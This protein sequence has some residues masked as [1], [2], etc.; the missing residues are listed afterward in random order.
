MTQR[1]DFPQ[2]QTH[3]QVEGL[4]RDF[5]RRHAGATSWKVWPKYEPQNNHG[6]VFI[7][8]GDNRQQIPYGLPDDRDELLDLAKGALNDMER[9]KVA[10]E[11]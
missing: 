11:P 2:V 3:E 4:I 8:F 9:W 5:V 6:S 1:Y 7:Q 10:P